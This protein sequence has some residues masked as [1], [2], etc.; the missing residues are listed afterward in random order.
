LLDIWGI[1]GSNIWISGLDLTTGQR[2]LLV[3]YNSVSLRIAYEYDPSIQSRRPDSISGVVV[4]AW[5]TSLYNVW[6]TTSAGEYVC[7]ATT[8]GEGRLS[9]APQYLIGFPWRLRGSNK[10]N[11]AVVGDFGTIAHYNGV[12]WHHFIEFMQ[13]YDPSAPHFRSVAVTDQLIMAVGTK[14]GKAVV[15]IGRR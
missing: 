12:T 6:V 13:L 8:Q 14:S 1:G 9:W 7:P 10:N 3:H 5:T 2:S 15:L 11:I 4:S